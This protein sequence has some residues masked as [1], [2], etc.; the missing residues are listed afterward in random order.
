MN[1]DAIHLE[2][3][4]D[5]WLDDATHGLPK[6]ARSWVRDELLAHYDDALDAHLQ[7]GAS[8]EE[9]QR[10][11]LTELG[12]A[13]SISGGL[14]ET[15]LAEQR[16]RFAAATSLIFPLTMVAHIVLTARGEGGVAV[17]LYDLLLLLPLLYVL[18]CLHTLF[19][20]RFNLNVGRRLQL[21]AVGLLGMTLPEILMDGY[22]LTLQNGLAP[23]P[24]PLVLGALNALMLIDLIGAVILGI[25]FVWLAEA[26]LRVRDARLWSL[27]PFCYVTLINGY[28]LAL[29]SALGVVGQN[30]L[31]NLAWSL[32]LVL[33]IVMHALW[34]LM[35]TRAAQPTRPA[36]AA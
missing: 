28:T 15:H 19:V 10:S 34:L 24:S 11:A 29:T 17:L 33:G 32:A 23:H 5:R 14:R 12:S 20:Q 9:A 31:Y 18:R 21:V 4:R 25:G 26:L 3:V 1:A 2:E 7:D 13:R 35:F 16:Y 27:R 22:W 8:L 30:E 6:A 36:F